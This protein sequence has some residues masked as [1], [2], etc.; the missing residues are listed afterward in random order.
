MT[1]NLTGNYSE[2]KKK[3]KKKKKTK[4]KKKKKKKKG[5]PWPMKNFSNK[6]RAFNFTV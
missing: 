6:I 4:K 1:K 2:K 3:K 5:T